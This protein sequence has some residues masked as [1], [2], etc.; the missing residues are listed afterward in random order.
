MLSTVNSSDRIIEIL[1][2]FSTVKLFLSN[3]KQRVFAV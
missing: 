3:I 2:K 1:V